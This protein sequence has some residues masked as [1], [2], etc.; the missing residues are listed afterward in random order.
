V[1]DILDFSLITSGRLK[2]KDDEVDIREVISSLCKSLSLTSSQKPIE[3]VY[4]IDDEVPSKINGDAL[5]LQQILTN[6]VQLF[7]CPV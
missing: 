1:D 4:D 2:L 3:W 5:R 6:L 7:L